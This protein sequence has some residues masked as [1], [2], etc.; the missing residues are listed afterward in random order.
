ME[1]D[2]MYV[3]VRVSL[4]GYETKV[5]SIPLELND[6][7]V[8][9]GINWL[10]KHMAQVDCYTKTITFQRLK[11]RKVVFKGERISIPI[12]L[13]SIVIARKLHKKGCVG[14][15]VYVLNSNGGE[16][17]LSD[18]LV[19]REFLNVFP[20]KLRGLP[21]DRKVEVSINTFLEVPL[22]AQPS[23]S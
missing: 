7:D 3:G 8:I 9:L 22:I 6:F 1:I 23:Y 5:I 10:S 18:I 17:R 4:V 19:I 15:L 12:N 11:G 14:Y 20:E 16:L 21:P 2:R 13:V